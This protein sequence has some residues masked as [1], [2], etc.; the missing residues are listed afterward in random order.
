M[1]PEAYRFVEK[2]DYAV[3]SASKNRNQLIE[4]LGKTILEIKGVGTSE[5]SAD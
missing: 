3:D 2:M 4:D 1:T 5:S